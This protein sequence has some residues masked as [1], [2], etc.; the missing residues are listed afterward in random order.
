[1]ESIKKSLDHKYI[2]IVP[3]SEEEPGPGKAWYLPV[4]SVL[5]TK[6]NKYRLVYDAA[7]RYN[8][9][10][11]NDMLIQG[12]DLNNRLRG[13]LLRFRERPV[14]I[15]ADIEAMFNNFKVPEEQRDLLRFFWY[16]DNN[17]SLPL[18]TYRATSHIF[19][20]NSSPAVAIYGL[21]FCATE[22]WPEEYNDAKQYINSFYMDDGLFSADSAE[23]A[24]NILLYFVK[25]REILI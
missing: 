12:P 5:Q 19:G 20:C 24:T 13:V 18:A 11:L 1:M 2:E 17:C 9:L 22:S 25:A 21:K 7:A 16:Q 15:G 6:K 23:T 10:S 8:G 4:F 14:A 3:S